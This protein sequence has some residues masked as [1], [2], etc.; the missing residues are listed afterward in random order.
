MAKAYNLKALHPIKINDL[1]RVGRSYDGGYVLSK[2]QIE[3]TKTLLSFGIC[4][5]WSFEK[6]YKELSNQDIKLYALDASVS[7]NQFQTQSKQHFVNMLVRSLTGNISQAKKNKIYW[8]DSSK[9]AKSFKSF[10]SSE[11]NNYFM[12]KFLGQKDDDLYISVKTLFQKYVGE[13][14]DLSVFVKMDIENWE[15]R[16]LYQ[17]TPFFS[18]IN[19]FAVEFHELDI[20][21]GK[22]EE[23]IEILSSDF[24]IAHVHANNAGGLIHGT[25]LPVLLEITFINKQIAPGPELSLESY[26]IAGLDFPNIKEEAD[27]PLIFK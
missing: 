26:P 14:K 25:D 16:T 24:H 7:F 5:D 21:S 19:G 18:K 11:L 10:F 15:Y 8:N 20:T 2:T 27:I 23:T 13:A 17:F 1:I 9:I 6:H 3:K 22:F 12:P 4:N